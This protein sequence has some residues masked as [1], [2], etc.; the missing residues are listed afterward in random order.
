MKLLYTASIQRCKNPDDIH[1]K[2]WLMMQVQ[3]KNVKV[4]LRRQLQSTIINHWQVSN[5]WWW[6]D[7]YLHLLCTTHL[8]QW[9]HKGLIVHV[10]RC[11]ARKEA[12]Q[13]ILLIKIFEGKKRIFLQIIQLSSVE[14][15]IFSSALIAEYSR[16]KL[17]P[18][19]DEI[20]YFYILTESRGNEFRI[21]SWMQ[22]GP[23]LVT[24][25]RTKQ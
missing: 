1:R 15:A 14:L 23:V 13:P 25:V 22:G 24:F 11:S 19:E 2:K 10:K 20:W 18:E 6:Y 3:N 5:T 12:N 8:Q 17:S 7:N 16:W 9:I 4:E 21:R